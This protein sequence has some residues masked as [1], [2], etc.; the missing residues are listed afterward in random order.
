MNDADKVISWFHFDSRSNKR[1]VRIED[2][3]DYQD[4]K[5]VLTTE[6]GLVILGVTERDAGRYGHSTVTI[7][8]LVQDL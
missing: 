2:T 8:G 6:G 1:R 3:M 4:K 7:P 5:H